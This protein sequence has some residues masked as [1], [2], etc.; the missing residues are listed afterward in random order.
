MPNQSNI[1]KFK[2]SAGNNKGSPHVQHFINDLKVQ[3][4][5]SNLRPITWV[6]LYILY[7]LGGYNKPI[8]DPPGKAAVRATPAKQ[9]IAFKKLS[10][11]LSTHNVGG[12]LQSVF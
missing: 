10:R 6:E 11:G 1:H 3:P 9:M 8:D 5:D 12:G 7:R 2:K 4:I